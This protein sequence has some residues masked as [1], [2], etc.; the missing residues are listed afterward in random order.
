MVGLGIWEKPEMVKL[1]GESVVVRLGSVGDVCLC[2]I[3]FMHEGVF[4]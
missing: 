2:W 4:L 1:W 3:K